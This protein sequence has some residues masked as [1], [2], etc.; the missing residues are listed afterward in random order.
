MENPTQYWLPAKTGLGVISARFRLSP[1][2][3]RVMSVLL[4]K[5]VPV[6]VHIPIRTTRA[7]SAVGLIGIVKVLSVLTPLLVALIVKLATPA[8]VGVPEIVLPETD[9]PPV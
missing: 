4:V 1:E 3:G 6:E 9:R 7:V 5:P 2:V 8:V